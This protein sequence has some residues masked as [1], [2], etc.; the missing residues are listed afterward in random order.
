MLQTA[1]LIVLVVVSLAVIGLILIQQG[2]GADIGAAFGSGASN[3]VFGSQ[4]SGNFLTRATAILVTIFF[5]CCLALA[6]HANNVARKPAIDFSGGVELKEV[7]VAGEVP[8]APASGEA[9]GG[10]VPAAAS[11]SPGAAA[12]SSDAASSADVPATGSAAPAPAGDGK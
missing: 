1:L 11:A 12:P 8:V 5:I 4:G 6:W 7:P 2:K 10:D 9:A 3:S